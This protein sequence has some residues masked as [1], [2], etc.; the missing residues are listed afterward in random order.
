MGR[1]TP[2]AGM[3][4]PGISKVAGSG[5]N[6][7]RRGQ[8][9]Q[10]PVDLNQL[11]L[12]VSELGFE[13]RAPAKKQPA[14]SELLWIFSARGPTPS[15]GWRCEGTSTYPPKEQARRSRWSASKG[16]TLHPPGWPCSIAA[17]SQPNPAQSL[18]HRPPHS[19]RP[20]RPAALPARRTNSQN[21]CPMG[22]TQ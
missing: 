1:G 16:W 14:S 19:S 20:R 6:H 2:L 12:C 13:V 8:L 7:L 18:S 5:V 15:A 22:E 10:L 17:D 4:V 21:P 11:L 9:R 3:K